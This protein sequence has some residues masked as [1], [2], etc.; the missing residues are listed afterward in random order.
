LPAYALN[1]TDQVK[2]NEVSY[3]PGESPEEPFE[4]IEL[5]N[6]GATTVFLDGAAI[7]DEGN[8]GTGEGTFVFPG[9][10][11]G[12][13]IPLASHA[14]LVIVNDAT[15]STLPVD[16]EI[17][18]G[19][20]DPDAGGVPNL[21]RTAGTGTD[22][23]LGNSGDGC[24]AFHRRHDRQQHSLQRDRRRCQLR[25][26]RRPHRDLRHEQLGVQR[27]GF[28]PAIRTPRTPLTI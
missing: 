24:H 27:S 20:S 15:G 23:L 19:G 28:D 11:G 1:A 3:D 9:T 18:T 12:T 10:V 13:T 6:A 2:I 16:W 14:Y 25:R 4:F 26:R 22:L 17:F 8:A 5:Y 21:T 7:S